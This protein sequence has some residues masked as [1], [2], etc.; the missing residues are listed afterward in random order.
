MNLAG[1]ASKQRQRTARVFTPQAA[2]LGP[3]GRLGVAR[4]R[5]VRVGAQ[6]ARCGSVRGFVVAAGTRHRAGNAPDVDPRCIGQ[7]GLAQRDGVQHEAARAAPQAQ[8]GIG[9]AQ[10]VFGRSLLRKVAYFTGHAVRFV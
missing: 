2:G 5:L 10:V 1:Q 9:Q 7:T 3:Q 8:P 4:A 6:C